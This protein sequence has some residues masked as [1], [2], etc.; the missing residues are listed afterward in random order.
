MHEPIGNSELDELRGNPVGAP[1]TELLIRG[2]SAGG[3][4]MAYHFDADSSFKQKRVN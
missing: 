2:L 1:L 4:A 3:V